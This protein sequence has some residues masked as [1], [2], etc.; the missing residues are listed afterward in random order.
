MSRVQAFDTWAS[1]WIIAQVRQQLSA[2][3]T[4]A[5]LRK[6]GY[7]AAI[8]TW[9]L[10]RIPFDTSAEY[11]KPVGYDQYNQQEKAM[12]EEFMSHMWIAKVF[13]AVQ[14]V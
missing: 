11:I 5:T 6:E 13:V 9:F 7:K 10:V 3:L 2:P 1:A 4:K 14:L 8:A 12:F